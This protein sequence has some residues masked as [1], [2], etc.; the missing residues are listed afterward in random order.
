[1]YRNPFPMPEPQR[2]AAVAIIVAVAKSHGLPPGYLTTHTEIRKG[3]AV[4]REE[5]QR[6]ILA[7]VPEM[8]FSMLARAWGRDVRRIRELANGGSRRVIGSRVKRGVGPKRGRNS[9]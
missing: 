7:E 1:M 6:R 3:I 4:A 2:T 8:N 5:A 9:K